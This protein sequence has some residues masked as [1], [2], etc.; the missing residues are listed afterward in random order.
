MGPSAGLRALGRADLTLRMQVLVTSTYAVLGTAGA[1]A[2]GAG[3]MVWGTAT[4]S[5]LGAVA[6]WLALDRAARA[7]LPLPPATA[8]VEPEE[9]DDRVG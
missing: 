7:A 1:A 4:A 2:G 6:W 9:V 5:C 8:L 3:G